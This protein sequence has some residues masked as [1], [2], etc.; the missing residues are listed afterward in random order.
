MSFF[1]VPLA[2]AVTAAL[3]NAGICGGQVFSYVSE[4]TEKPYVL[5]EDF[6]ARTEHAQGIYVVHEQ[7]SIKVFD[8][9]ETLENGLI[10]RQQ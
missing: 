5:I 6:S 8:G 9:G 3:V 1:T 4:G 2:K 10:I 7:F